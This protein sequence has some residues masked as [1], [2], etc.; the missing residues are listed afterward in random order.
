MDKVRLALLDVI[1]GTGLQEI[2]CDNDNLKSFQDPL[3]CACFTI[4]NRK[5]GDRYF[6]IYCDDQGLLSD[7]PIPSAFNSELKPVLVGN[8]IFAHHDNYGETTELSD[9]DIAHLMAN[10]LAVFDPNAKGNWIAVYPI[11]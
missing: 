1:G 8:L 5:I 7:N 3:R 10:R 4:I 9:D 11:E 2:E 6:D